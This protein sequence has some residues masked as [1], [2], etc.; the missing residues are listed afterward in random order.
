MYNTFYMIQAVVYLI[1]HG[2]VT[3][4][5]LLTYGRVRNVSLSSEGKEQMVKLGKEIIGMG[6]IPA[7]IVSSPLSRGVQSAKVLLDFFPQAPIFYREELTES[8]SKDLV[9]RPLTWARSLLHPHEL[10][11][12][13]ELKIYIEPKEQQGE[14]MVRII[15]E[16]TSKHQGGTILFVGHG[17]PIAFAMDSLLHPSEPLHNINE[18]KPHIYL[19]RGQAWRLSVD[20]NLRILTHERL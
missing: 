15:R 5:L 19:L 7:C 1:R 6:D 8:D 13:K 14:R 16:F 12:Q 20:E 18:L 3:N 4:P 10:S 2:A 11:V 17:D 9:G